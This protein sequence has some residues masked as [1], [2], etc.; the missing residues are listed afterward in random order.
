[1]TVRACLGPSEGALTTVTPFIAL[2]AKAMKRDR[3]KCLEAGASD[4]IIKPVD[5]D[6][7][8]SLVKEWLYRMQVH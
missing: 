5:M 7:L 3:G 8:L 6:K 2:T 4:Y 1:M